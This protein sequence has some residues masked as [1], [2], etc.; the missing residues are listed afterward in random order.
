VRPATRV[1]AGF[2]IF[3]GLLWATTLTARAP[4]EAEFSAATTL[5]EDIGG[6]MAGLKDDRPESVGI[7]V[8]RANAPLEQ[9]YATLVEVEVLKNLAREGFEN[10]QSCPECKSPHAMVQ[11]DHLVISKGN[12]DPV[13]MKAIGSHYNV[14]TFL[15]I[16]LYRTTFSVIAQATLYENPEAT[17][18]ASERFRIPALNIADAP[19][20]VLITGGLGTVLQGKT[21]ITN[22]TYDTL[23]ANLSLLEEIGFGKGGLNLGA[24]M[25]PHGNGSL[26]YLNPTFA[27][28]GHFG[29][30]TMAWSWHLCAGYGLNSDAKGLVFRSAID[31]YLGPLAAVGVEGGYFLVNK[32]TSTLRSW[33]GLHI[34]LSL[35]R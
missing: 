20:Q 12:P 14:D 26:Y 18:V 8:V 22:R 27:L 30:S 17:V 9:D 5:G 1:C 29:R 31:I 6:W 11:G 16:D 3:V 23:L 35:G 19:A 33:A 4:D 13:T 7:F 32:A 34:G 21:P 10:V 28:R 15:V 24:V 25:D 2:F